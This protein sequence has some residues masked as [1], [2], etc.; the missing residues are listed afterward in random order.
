MF[1]VYL[2]PT[3][4]YFS[5]SSHIIFVPR[6]IRERNCLPCLLPSC[7]THGKPYQ[8]ITETHREE[9]T[10]NVE[11]QQVYYCSSSVSNSLDDGREKI[12]IKMSTIFSPFISI[13]SHLSI[14]SCNFS[15]NF[16]CLSI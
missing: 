15:P 3:F 10:K 1:N 13:P 14:L 9:S 6:K 16:Q 4:L 11:K 8:T 2:L 12:G 7:S 5:S